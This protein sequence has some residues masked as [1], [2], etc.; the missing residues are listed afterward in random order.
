MWMRKSQPERVIAEYLFIEYAEKQAK[1]MN[2]DQGWQCGFINVPESD[3]TQK[4]SFAAF[5]DFLLD[6]LSFSA[7]TYDHFKRKSVEL[8][9]YKFAIVES[10]GNITEYAAIDAKM[11]NELGKAARGL[12]IVGK[13]LD[14]HA[15]QETA[16]FRTWFDTYVKRTTSREAR[17]E[18]YV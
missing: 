3:F 1:P 15:V 12:M 9:D 13:N 2:D 14:L 8:T 6:E 16:T 7:R 18:D 17:E 5:R 4:D 10:S 11:L